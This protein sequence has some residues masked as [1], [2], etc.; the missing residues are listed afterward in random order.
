MQEEINVSLHARRMLKKALNRVKGRGATMGS[1]LLLGSR[2][3]WQKWDTHNLESWIF[4][5]LSFL[6]IFI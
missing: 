5:A 1:L 3:R 4:T 6:M 2:G